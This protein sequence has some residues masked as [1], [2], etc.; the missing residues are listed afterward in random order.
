MFISEFIR[1]FKKNE[2]QV[3]YNQSG[4]VGQSMSVRAKQAY[5][6]GEM[7]K[8]KWTKSAIIEELENMF[9]EEEASGFKKF[10]RQTL[11]DGVCSYSSW[12]HT[13]KFANA[14]EFYSIDR[15]NA[16]LFAE[17]NNIASMKETIEN[18][19]DYNQML[20]EKEKEAERYKKEKEE[21]KKKEEQI[22]KQRIEYVKTIYPKLPKIIS[23]S[24]SEIEEISHRGSKAFEF[25]FTMPD[26][27]LLYFHAYDKDK[28]ELESLYKDLK[29]KT[30]NKKTDDI[31]K[32]IC[33]VTAQ[34]IM[35]GYENWK[36]NEYGL[37]LG[38]GVWKDWNIKQLP[39]YQPEFS[40]E[41]EEALN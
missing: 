31:Y 36:R 40:V 18:D 7:P 5:D 17:E 4:Y 32:Y 38:N 16:L 27:Y 41:V 26:D 8:S 28:E 20:A 22:K 9:G 1:N 25:S 15:N 12:H 13:G 23:D 19:E 3:R 39:L 6:S 29:N 14:T 33:D 21:E 30:K 11:F 24:L 37:V 34:S 10:S 2:A 35:N